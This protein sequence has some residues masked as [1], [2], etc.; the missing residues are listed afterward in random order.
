MSNNK[1]KS[2]D[3][4]F[5]GDSNNPFFGLLHEDYQEKEVEGENCKYSISQHIFF[6]EMNQSAEEIKT[7]LEKRLAVPFETK[8]SDKSLKNY[9]NLKVRY[10]LIVSEQNKQIAIYF[11]RVYTA[12]DMI[13]IN[14]HS[15]E[16]NKK[17]Y[18]IFNET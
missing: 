3:L 4:L 11:D 15:K 16:M 7:F 5:M 2:L 18:C 8:S 17:F 1:E 14:K 10:T 12:G 6:R 13:S 9:K